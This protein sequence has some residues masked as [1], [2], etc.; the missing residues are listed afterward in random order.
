MASSALCLALVLVGVEEDSLLFLRLRLPSW[1]RG[2]GVEEGESSVLDE[3]NLQNLRI[4]LKL[5]MAQPMQKSMPH[6]A[7][8]A[9]VVTATMFCVE[10]RSEED[11]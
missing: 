8:T 3:S 5:A 10:Q 7:M 2:A 6:T 9:E 1:D 11:P 4:C